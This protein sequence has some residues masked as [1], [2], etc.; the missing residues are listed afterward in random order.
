MSEPRRAALV[1]EG[2][3]DV[4]IFREVI[5]ELWPSVTDVDCLQPELD[6]TGRATGRAGWSE[7][8][9][10]CEQHV[11]DLEDVL[12]PDVGFPFD[13]L[14]IAIDVDIAIAAGIADPPR[15][16]GNYES[17]RLRETMRGWLQTRNRRRVPEVVV[18]STPVMAI[19]AWVIAAL[20]PRRNAPESI[21]DPATELVNKR[22][23]RLS[24]NDGKPWKELYRYKLFSKQVAGALARVR[25]K[26]PEA[27]R[28]C[29]EIEKV[30]DAAE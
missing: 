13:L 11:D 12:Q 19:E 4:P 7:V 28:T 25:R 10:W 23:L 22:K 24:P 14:L 20:F 21:A 17:S 5:Q 27:G 2:Q 6:D 29:Q 18:L 3:T 15:S 8:K 1:C 9:A 16:V 30:R 26:C